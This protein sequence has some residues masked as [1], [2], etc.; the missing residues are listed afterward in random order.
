VTYGKVN[1][2]KARRIVKEHIL[3]GKVVNEFVFAQEK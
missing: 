3:G 2:D 1:P